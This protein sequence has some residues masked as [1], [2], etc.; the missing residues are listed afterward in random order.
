M[1]RNAPRLR[2]LAPRIQAAAPR[3]REP[4][5]T[6]WRAGKTSSAARGYGYRWQKR[7]EQQ[8][9]KEPLCRMCEAQGRVTAATVADHVTPHRGDPALFDGSLQSLCATCHSSVKQR[10]DIWRT[11]PRR[12]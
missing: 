12:L 7:R 2:T 3:L 6:G 9:R 5:G 10:E 11:I 4:T 1:A 8:L